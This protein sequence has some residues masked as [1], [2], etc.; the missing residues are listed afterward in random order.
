MGKSTL[1]VVHGAAGVRDATPV[2]KGVYMG[3]IDQIKQLAAEGKLDPQG[4]R[5]YLR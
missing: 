1:L 2:V 4:V 5:F 3:G